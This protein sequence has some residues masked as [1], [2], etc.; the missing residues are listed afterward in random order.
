MSKIFHYSRIANFYETDAANI[1]HF[2][3]YFKYL[4]E[5]ELAF[6]DS[7]SQ[8]D[9][10]K[11]VWVRSNI[12]CQFRMPIR[13]ED[14]FTIELVMISANQKRICYEFTIYVKNKL[15]AKGSYTVK[16]LSLLDSNN[17]KVFDQRLIDAINRI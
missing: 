8:I 10:S 16:P 17:Q 11:E 3:N 1:V 13:F 5:A 6:I 7:L 4:E 12:F 14:S 2:S 15:C 9:T